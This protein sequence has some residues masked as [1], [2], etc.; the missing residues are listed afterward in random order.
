LDGRLLVATGDGAVRLLRVQRE[1][2]GPQD[3]ET[4]LRG[5]PVAAGT[6]LG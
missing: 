3:A 5:Q 1:G 2:R 6:V 4:F